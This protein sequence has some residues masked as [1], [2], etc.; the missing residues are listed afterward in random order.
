MGQVL[1]DETLIF[2]VVTN[3]S[4][5]FL[6]VMKRS[7]NAALIKIYTRSDPLLHSCCDGINARES[8]LYCQIEVRKYQIKTIQWVW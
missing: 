2:S 6:P 8:I 1:S 5:V 7:L 3:F 4:Y